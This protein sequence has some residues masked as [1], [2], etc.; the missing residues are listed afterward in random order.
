MYFFL[1]GNAYV[2]V[3]ARKTLHDLTFVSPSSSVF[4]LE[5]GGATHAPLIL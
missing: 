5:G 2:G 4:F 3:I 1:P